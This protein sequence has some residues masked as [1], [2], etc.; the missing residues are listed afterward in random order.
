MDENNQY[1]NAITGVIKKN[2][3]KKFNLI[4]FN[5]SLE[6]ILDEDKIG[7]LF[8]V[9]VKFDEKNANEKTMM[10]NEI[11]TLKFEKEK[12]MNPTERSVF[13]LLDVIRLN[14]KGL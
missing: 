11:Y 13:Q 4:E 10:F 6:Q 3:I 5:L 2:V 12:V 9:D 14:D 8:I 1:G 7:H